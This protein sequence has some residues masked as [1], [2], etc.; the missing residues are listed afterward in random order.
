MR[1]TVPHPRLRYVQSWSSPHL[2]YLTSPHLEDILSCSPH[3]LYP[4]HLQL[5][6]SLS[7]KGSDDVIEHYEKGQH[8]D[9]EVNEDPAFAKRTLRRVDSN[10]LPILAIL[11]SISLIDRVNIS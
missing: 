6:M 7:E 2:D 5:T 11:Y 9:P 3:S 1:P 4:A 10:L 8:V